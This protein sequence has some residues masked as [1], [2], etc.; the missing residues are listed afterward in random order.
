[1]PLK[2]ALFLALASISVLIA[3]S[4]CG[5]SA[6]G[7]EKAVLGPVAGYIRCV[8]GPEPQT[9]D[10]RKSRGLSE[11]R[12]E[13]NLFEGLI[14]YGKDGALVG[15]AAEKWTVSPDGRVYTFTLRA[16][17]RWSNGD[18]VTAA[19]FEYAWKKT[20]DPRFDSK[21]ALLLYF[22]KGAQDY[23]TGKGPAEAV[24]VKALDERTLEVTLEQPVPF[25]LS[26]LA[27]HAFYPVNRRVDESSPL[28]MTSAKAF[29]GNGAFVLKAWRP[30]SRI[31]TVKNPYYWDAANVKTGRLD[32]LLP[33]SS[34]AAL[35]LFDAG[36]ADYYDD[37][38]DALSSAAIERFQKDGSLKTAP[39]LAAVYCVLNVSTKK[40]PLSNA[41]LRKAFSL[42]IDREELARIAGGG[43]VAAYAL[44]PPGVPDAAKGSDFRKEGGNLVEGL[45]VAKAQRLLAEAGH[46]G[47]KG[48]PAFALTFR[49]GETNA[50]V[51]K[52]IKDM[53]KENLGVTA[54]LQQQKWDAFR[55]NLACGNYQIACNV[56][57][58]EIA[59]PLAFLNL[60]ESRSG[61]NASKY[62]NPRYDQA[63]RQSCGLPSSE[64]MRLLHEMEKYIITDEMVVLPL[65]FVPQNV[66]AKPY[67]KGCITTP[68]GIT[69]F[70]YA[71]VS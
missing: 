17:A 70:K 36:Q 71:Y 62:S 33:D 21:N 8:T 4:G 28:W 66:L 20:L 10:P 16:N 44:V 59:D 14:T 58:G 56:R 23:N 51:A 5:G 65:Y 52:A 40:V 49:A 11:A 39:C 22:L 19:D 64:R 54:I 25:F 31:E 53:L 37:C 63:L 2:K 67:L 32:F 38:L 30:G 69:Y 26:M 47:G 9:L 6:G 24:G 35:A 48:L 7:D 61:S 29:V 57:V 34:A 27:H 60:F 55:Q 50:A 42:A 68:D 43:A 45:N 18:P 3:A 41:M 13:A 12:I 1:M 15:G 46:P